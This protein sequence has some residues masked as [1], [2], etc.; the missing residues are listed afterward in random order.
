MAFNV[1]RGVRLHWE[2]PL[3]SLKRHFDPKSI[4][5]PGGR[6]GLDDIPARR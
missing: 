6:L 1:K 3:Q 4:M 5:N 2:E